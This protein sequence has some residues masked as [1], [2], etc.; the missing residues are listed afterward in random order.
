[1]YYSTT[2]NTAPNTIKHLKQNTL[3]RK[4]KHPLFRVLYKIYNRKQKT[5]S[6]FM[7][8]LLTLPYAA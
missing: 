4:F 7:N 1:M 2:A 3:K 6:L 8:I 5:D